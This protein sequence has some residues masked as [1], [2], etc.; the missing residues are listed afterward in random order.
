VGTV[1]EA[2]RTR[3]RDRTGHPTQKPEGLVRFLVALASPPAGS[4]ID[5]FAGSGTT[6][7]AARA[8]GRTAIGI[9]RSMRACR[10]AMGRLGSGAV[11]P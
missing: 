5:P 4:V 8:M 9:D 6:L 11:A 1:I 3:R 10:I 2:S 7:V